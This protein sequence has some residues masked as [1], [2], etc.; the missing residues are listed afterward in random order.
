MSLTA[1]HDDEVVGMH[2]L[3]K[4]GIKSGLDDDM[5]LIKPHIYSKSVIFRRSGVE[6]DRLVCMLAEL[7][8]ISI[9]INK[10]VERETFTVIALH[11]GDLDFSSMGVKLKL[12]GKDE[13][14]FDDD[15]YYESFLN[16]DLANQL[17]F[18]NEKDTDY[19]Q[20][21]INA[22]AFQSD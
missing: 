15:A 18:W 7:Y 2:V 6:S 20:Q 19:R 9:D 17:V 11:Q 16:I 3:F 14:P 13:E 8:G 4:E 5:N 12:F 10:M 1:S 21:L 22:L